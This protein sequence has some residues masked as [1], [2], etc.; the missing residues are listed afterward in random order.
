MV[1][2]QVYS[3]TESFI[4]GEAT[5]KKI[6]SQYISGRITQSKN[7]QRKFAAGTGT[8]QLPETIPGEIYLEPGIHS[9]FCIHDKFIPA[10]PGKN[11]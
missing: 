3:H 9:P 1:I 8:F 2:L 4:Y 7:K 11:D 6:K 5:W 10:F